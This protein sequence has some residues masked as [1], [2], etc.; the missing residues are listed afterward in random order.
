MMGRAIEVDFLYHKVSTFTPAGV[1]F[2]RKPPVYLR[3]GDVI[4][5]EVERVGV[6]TNP[7]VGPVQRERTV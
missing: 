4:E 1:G 5:I 7:V 3:A 6:I 2:V